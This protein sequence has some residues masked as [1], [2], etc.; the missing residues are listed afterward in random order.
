LGQPFEHFDSAVLPRGDPHLKLSRYPPQRRHRDTGQGVGWH[1]DS[2][3]VSFVLQ[4][5]VGGLEVE[6]GD[7]IVE[8]TPKPGTYVMNL[9]EMLQAATS[10][11]LRATKHRVRS[12]RGRE[13]RLS[14]AYFFHPRL[15]CVFDPVAL[16]PELAAAARGGN[17]KDPRDPVFRVFGENYL[18]IR[19]RS[20]PDVAA[21][22]YSDVLRPIE[23]PRATRVDD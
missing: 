20:H 5:G 14:V 7:A 4:D 6:L 8:A 17:N 22:H 10:G 3:L 13:A 16:P 15:D 23:P 2:G 1:H 11:Y 12:P 21:A 19:L 9:G 18:K